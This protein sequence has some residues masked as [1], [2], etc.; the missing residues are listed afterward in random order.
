MNLQR[1]R[2]FRSLLLAC[3]AAALA[4]CSTVSNSPPTTTPGGVPIDATRTAKG[5]D[6]RAMFLVIH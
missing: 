1:L 3:L 4:A 6:S 5:Q 2:G